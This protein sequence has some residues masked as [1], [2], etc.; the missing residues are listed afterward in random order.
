[1][2]KT[3]P[4]KEKKDSFKQ[5]L[6]PSFVFWPVSGEN[7]LAMGELEPRS[8]FNDSEPSGIQ[9]LESGP[10]EF[11]QRN[12]SSTITRNHGAPVCKPGPTFHLVGIQ[13]TRLFR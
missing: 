13:E 3:V 7:M 2:S 6:K 5:L 8:S 9:C 4:G 11:T 10:A 12:L 1:M